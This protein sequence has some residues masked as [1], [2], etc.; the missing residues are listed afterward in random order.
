[1]ALP[2][3]VLKKREDRRIR[4]GHLWVFSNEV[5]R[6]PQAGAGALVEVLDSQGKSL[7][8]GL[9]HPNSLISARL[10]GGVIEALDPDFFRE[11]IGAA[12]RLR[13]N[14]FPGEECYRLIHGESDFLPG[15]LVDRFGD[16]LVLQTL[17][18]GMEARLELICN[19]L[20]ELLGPAAILERNDNRLRAYEDLPFRNGVLRG[21]EAGPLLLRESGI[22]YRID[23][24]RGQ[25][26]GFFLDQK[27]NRQA[28]AAYCRGRS[29]LDCFCNVGG[30]ALQ[31]AKAGAVKVR[32]IDASQAAVTQARENAVL[33]GLEGVEFI[34]SDVFDFLD[35]ER[36]A[37]T[38]W[39]VVIL[40][41]P[42]FTRSKKNVASAKQGYQKLNEKAI[43]LIEPEGILATASCSFHIFEEVFEE[44]V[45]EAA[46]RAGRTLQLLEWRR[47]SP[48]HPVLPAMPE[49]K[50]LKLGIYR[51]L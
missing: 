24:L 19:A 48:D 10:L 34:Q 22:F 12:A 31:A 11:R 15:L 28:V 26:T 49:T 27:V 23:L 8:S 43:Q 36:S 37:R 41:P 39:D 40:D 16:H 20:E 18:A 1:M 51:V 4:A 38:H 30:F 21:T 5:A 46:L 29:V 25:K 44:I 17:T 42:S 45:Q 32:A 33:N 9:Y 50:Y 2:Q 6:H 13:E 35:L 47:Q 14:L 7:G 3:L